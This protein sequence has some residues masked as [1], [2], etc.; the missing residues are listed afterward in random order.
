MGLVAC[1]VGCAAGFTSGGGTC[2]SGLASG[3]AAGATG[4]T[5]FGDRIRNV[6][7]GK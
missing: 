3:V 7:L 2:P 4:F 1:P 5:S 6:E